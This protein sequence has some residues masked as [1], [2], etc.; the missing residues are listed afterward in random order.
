MSPKTWI[1]YFLD[2]TGFSGIVI[3]VIIVG[4]VAV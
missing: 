4:A 2:F 1:S 3:E